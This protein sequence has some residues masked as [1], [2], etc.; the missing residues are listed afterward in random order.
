MSISVLKNFPEVWD[1]SRPRRERDRKSRG[2]WDCRRSETPGGTGRAVSGVYGKRRVSRKEGE[3]RTTRDGQEV[4]S[5]VRRNRRI[6]RDTLERC[7][8]SRTQSRYY[9]NFRN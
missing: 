9:S 6:R 1:P 3:G 5:D 8:V 4:Q 2:R 7:N